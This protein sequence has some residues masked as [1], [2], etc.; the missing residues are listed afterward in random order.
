MRLLHL[1][2]LHIGKQFYGYSLVEDQKYFFDQIL[3]QIPEKKIE[4][5]ILAG[6]IYDRAIPSQEAVDLFDYFLDELINTHHLPVFC[7]S[8]NHDSAN[9]LHFASGILKKHGLHIETNLQEK[10]RFV[11]IEDE[12]GPLNIY[13]LPFFKQS[14]LRNL[15]E[16]ENKDTLETLF[17]TYM[18]MQSIDEKKRNLII[19]HGFVTGGRVEDETSVGGL[20][21]MSAHDFEKFDYV[22]LGHIHQ[23]KKVMGENMYYAGSPLVYS[24]DELGQYKA[25]LIVELKEKGHV[26]VEHWQIEPLR[27]VLKVEGYLDDLRKME[28]CHDY[29]FVYL[30]DENMKSMAANILRVVYPNLLGLTYNFNLNQEQY[31]LPEYVAYQQTDL[32]LFKDFYR[33]MTGMEVSKI[34]LDLFNELRGEDE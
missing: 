6:D 9:R 2:D 5:V 33:E 1:G 8:G 20:E 17:H 30:K 4:G 31:H 34:Y 16:T 27:K 14:S 13:F 11:S 3:N 15:L 29:V 10:L 25:L 21:W 12:Y 7:I 19:G 22:A 28:P 32:D 18:A 26:E 24:L 23:T